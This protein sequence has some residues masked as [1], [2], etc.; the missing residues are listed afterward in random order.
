[1]RSSVFA[2]AAATCLSVACVGVA[3][4][5]DLP[6]Q[7]PSYRAP[8]VVPVP[9]ISWTGVYAGI[10]GGG[11][12]ATDRVRNVT[13]SAEFPAGF[14][15]STNHPNGAFVGGYIGANYQFNQVVVGIDG[16]YSWSFLKGLSTNTGPTG[17]AANVDERIKWI[18]TG[19]GRLGVL[20]GANNAWLLYGKGG[21]AWA[22]F[23][24]DA[25]IFNAA[26]VNTSVASNSETRSGWVAGGGV[27]WMFMPNL[28]FKAEY[29][30]IDFGTT[31]FNTT[32]RALGTG[33]IT[34]FGRSADTTIHVAKFGAAYKF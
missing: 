17:S 6:I 13:G 32:S 1:M 30:Y 22:G 9:V 20:L 26:G 2:A 3:A 19:T 28:L 29:N 23:D 18:A 27:E 8:A 33:V 34:V 15:Q 25:M 12:W 24:T 5:A 14:V 31:N 11:G 21:W 7:Q 16:D 4:A 10:Q